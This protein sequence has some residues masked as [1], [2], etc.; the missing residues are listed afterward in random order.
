MK[1]KL[2]IVFIFIIL[3]LSSMYPSHI[4]ALK[5]KTH[6]AINIEIAKR[7]INGFSLNEYTTVRLK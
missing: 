2:Q 3:T 4:L 1:S 6:E 5:K 7:S